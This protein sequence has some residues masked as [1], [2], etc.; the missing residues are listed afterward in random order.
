MQRRDA[1]PNV[2]GEDG[3]VHGI[4]AGLFTPAL[5]APPRLGVGPVERSDGRGA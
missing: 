1:P 2:A 4:H 3:L 5:G